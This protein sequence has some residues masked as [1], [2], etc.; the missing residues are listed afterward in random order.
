VG[1]LTQLVNAFLSTLTL[2]TDQLS[3]EVQFL[4]RIFIGIEIVTAAAFWFWAQEQIVTLLSFKVVRIGLFIL[5]VGQWFFLCALFRDSMLWTASQIGGGAISVETFLDPSLLASSGFIASETIWKWLKN[6]TGWAAIFNIG[7]TIMFV[8]ALLGI[9][10]AFVLTSLNL[11][12][13]LVIFQFFCAFLIIFIAFG[14]FTGTNFLAERSLGGIISSSI[15]MGLVAAAVSIGVPIVKAYVLPDPTVDIDPT[16]RQAFVL[17]AAT[18]G[19]FL[20]SL[21][22]PSLAAAMF[23]GG[24]ILSASSMVMGGFR[25]FQAGTSL[26]FGTADKITGSSSLVR[27]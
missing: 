21:I 9:W 22:V 6:T 5:L 26:V 8:I 7:T 19:M 25:G 18:W 4:L 27:P 20:I 16:M 11:S 1:I 17:A 24:P 13:S 2:G 14:V 12:I 23:E 3:A 10:A 15:R